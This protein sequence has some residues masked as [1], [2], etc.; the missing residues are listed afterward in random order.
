[1]SKTILIAGKDYPQSQQFSAIASDN[2]YN[3]LITTSPNSHISQDESVEIISWNRTSPI[4]ARSAIVQAENKFSKLNECL[5]IFDAKSFASEYTDCDIQGFSKAIDNMIV[6]YCYLTTELIKRFENQHGG[7]IA[8]YLKQSPSYSTVTKQ[9]TEKKMLP[10]PVAM[11][12]DAFKS[13]AENLTGQYISSI[14]VQT[15]LFCSDDE[16][17]DREAASWIFASLREQDL[18]ETPNSM[19]WNRHGMKQGGVFSIFR[20]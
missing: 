10:L 16:I 4:S 2:E 18:K 11:A 17:S 5:I 14:D 3:V 7:R 19:K 8:F 13:F 6:G 20:K 1:M 12:Q 9:V 15:S